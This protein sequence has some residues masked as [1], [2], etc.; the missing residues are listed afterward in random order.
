MKASEINLSRFLSQPDTKFVIPVYQ[1]NYDWEHSQCKQ[2]IDDVLQVGKD[3]NINGHFIGSIVYIHDDIYST[4]GIRELTIIDGQQRLTTITLIY[5][6]LTEIAKE[7]DDKNEFNRINEKYLINKFAEGEKLKLRPTLNNDEA[8]R[9]LL[10]GGDY[11]DYNG[12]SRII[13]NF[14]Y[15]KNRITNENHKVIED[16]LNKLMFVEISLDREK[17]DPQRIFESL[18]S[19]GLELTQADLIR[20][21][22][23]MGLSREKQTRAYEKYWKPIEENAREEASNSNKVSA[24]IRDFLT[25]KNKK[26][27]RKKNVYQEFKNKYSFSGYEN[28]ERDIGPM[29]TMVKHYFKLLNPEKVK[30]KDISLELKYIKHLEINVAYPFLMKVY[31][32]YESSILSKNVLI[33]ILKLIQSF[34]WRRFIISLPTNAL[35]KIFMRLYED[36]D[37][38]DYLQSIQKALVKKQGNQR[39]PSDLE[40]KEH[41]KR[42]DMY[43]IQSKN[44]TY[45]FQRLEN[46]NNKEH[47]EIVGNN[48]ITIE[49]IFPQNPV[50]KWKDVLGK[51]FFTFQD[52]YLNTAANLTLSG[53]NGQLGN[54]IF[55]EKRDMNYDGGEQGYRFSRLWLNRYLQSINQWTETEINHRYNLIQKRFFQVWPMP[56]VSYDPQSNT[57]EINIFDVDDPTGK[58]IEYA[59]FLNERLKHKQVSKLYQDIFGRLFELE[60]QTFFNTD[61]CE[62]IGLTKNSKEC[63]QPVSLSDT[64]FIE[65]NLDNKNKFMK[66]QYA[67]TIFGFEDELFVKFR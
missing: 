60:P 27:P 42:K 47:V 28:I 51:Q 24:F 62:T 4:S 23:L 5:L 20:N 63:R 8:L 54:K 43:N 19:T 39:F 38:N 30:D 32:D 52:Q 34:V 15:F 58:K 45:F 31:D 3:K 13:E 25:F 17:D 55:I 18:N 9:Y 33:T 64:Y 53:N 65:G 12:Y 57:E 44:R 67:L 11:K 59:V 21:Y 37:H 6:I 49:H 40:I 36:V 26:I 61:L 66:L 50:A 48:S 46:H 41:L 22:I 10:N 35:N 1:R 29:R 2:L 14:E 7:A 56:D 16:G